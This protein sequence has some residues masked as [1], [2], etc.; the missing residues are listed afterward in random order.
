MS[1]TTE[2]QTLSAKIIPAR[3]VRFANGSHG[4]HHPALA[5]AQTKEPKITLIKDGDTVTAIEV[6]CGCGAVTRLDCQY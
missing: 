3:N 1:G 5:H 2:N 4:P 6:E